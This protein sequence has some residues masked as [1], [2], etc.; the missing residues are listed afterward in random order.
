MNPHG[1]QNTK[2]KVLKKSTV[3]VFGQDP[4]V[5]VANISLFAVFPYLPGL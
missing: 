3:A 2:A 5:D 1:P 4:K